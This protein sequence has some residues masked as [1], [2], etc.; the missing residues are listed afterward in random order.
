MEDRE[1]SSL[2]KVVSLNPRGVNDP[3]PVSDVLF[4]EDWERNRTGNLGAML[5]AAQIRR[6][7]PDLAAAIERGLKATS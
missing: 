7:N 1:T 2:T 5:R 3:K 6:S 4:L